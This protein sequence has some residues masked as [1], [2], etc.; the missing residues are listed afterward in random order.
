MFNILFITSNYIED[1][2]L[3]KA[4]KELEEMYLNEFQFYFYKSEEIDNSYQEFEKK[5]I[6]PNIIF[7]LL[8]GELEKFKKYSILK[9]KYAK[10]IPIFLNTTSSNDIMEINKMRLIKI[11]DFYNMTKYVLNG[12]IE[13][14]KNLILYVASKFG[15]KKYTY[16]ESKTIKTEGI[17]Y[18][19]RIVENEDEFL[20]S[21][22]NKKVIV[23]LFHSKDW[24]NKRKKVVDKFLEEIENNGMLGIG[25]F[26]NL[27]SKDLNG[28]KGIDWIIENYLKHN[29]KIIPKVI[30]NL[31]SYSLTVFSKHNK[32]EDRK[33]IFEDLN[34]PIIQAMSTYQERKEWESSIR[35]LDSESLAINVYYPEFDGQIITVT[36]CTYENIKDEIGERKIFIPIE[37]RVT[38]IVKIAKGWLKLSEKRNEEKKIAIIFHNMPPRNDMIGRAFGLDS[39]KSVYNMVELFKKNGIK[40]NYNFKNS[41]EIINKIIKGVSNDHKWL[42]AQK[43]LERS[44]DKINKKKYEIWFSE[45][46]LKV[47]SEMEK[48]WGKAPG[49]FMNYNE[50]FPI[51]GIIN[52]N[53]FIGLQPPR[54]IE[55]KADEIYHSTKFVIPHQY[56]AFYHWIKDIFK[57]DVIY[58]MGTHGTLEWLPGKEVGLSESCYPD[59]NIDDIPHLYPYSVNISGEGLQAKRRSNAVLISHMIP[60]LT[61]AGGYDEIEEIEELIKQYYH[62]K[63]INDK[64]I[65][66]IE[67]EII[68]LYFKYNYINDLKINFEEIERDF[69]VFLNKFHLYIDEIKSSVIKDGLHILGEIPDEK[70]LVGLIYNI[71][72]IK[73]NEMLAIDELVGKAIG[74]NIVE[75]KD[76]I[77]LSKI[78]ELSHKVIK[79]ILENKKIDKIE[80]YEIEDRKLIDM[81]KNYVLEIILPK[82]YGIK[83]E[84]ESIINGLNGKFVKPGES[85][86]IT[87]GNLNILPTGT[88]F[89]AIDPYK[90]PTKLS[91]K[92]GVNLAELLIERYRRDEGEL[93]KSIAMVLYSGDTIKTNGDDI[94]EILYLMGIKPIWEKNSEKVIGLEV[95]PLEEL[96]RPR[97]DV[98]L[99]ISGLFR[100]TFPVLIKMIDDAVNLVA[101]L[102]E[103]IEDNYI[104]KNIEEDIKKLIEMG[105]DQLEA[106]RKSKVR[107]F[108]CPPGTYGTGIRTLI[109]NKNWKDRKD[110][111]E[112]YINWSSYG[113][114]N[115]YHGEK[116]VTIFKEKLKRVSLTIK[117]EAS[118]E[119]DMLESDDY[120][121]YHGGLKVAVT[122]L[123]EEEVRSYSG[124]TSDID[125]IKIKSLNEESSRIM[126]ARILN[127]KWIEGLKKHD[128]KGAV[129]MSSML[130]TVFGWDATAQI[131]E[132]WMYDKILEKYLIDENTRKWL[133]KNNIHALLNMSERLLEAERRGMWKT[134][135][136]NIEVLTRIYLD[137][138][139]KV[140]EYE[141]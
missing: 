20:K 50:N 117:N 127:P 102:D 94:A 39:V 134:R 41:N 64:K 95:I 90:I 35:G 19:G 92:V 17:Y 108:G 89:Y 140:E 103:N 76:L 116:M 122:S 23:V 96:G 130:D 4:C 100:D 75:N 79:D 77:I 57:A 10:K 52:G 2:L 25:I 129:E 81:L 123:K 135:K 36:S 128:Y 1:Y 112:V 115:D 59:F 66:K 6:N 47:Q 12:G 85:G 34:I 37:N 49:T 14:Y 18:N 62:A 63:N 87:R 61:L 21:I 30:I 80:N 53:I 104:K 3:K 43:I 40:T 65:K 132:D 31:L 118:N 98:T 54:G 78:R 99:R 33:S 27:S 97:I 83:N 58:H 7:I 67:K 121:A 9:E 68:E 106:E 45:L 86:Y 51:P 46:N 126:R 125:N 26:T 69:S 107:V 114:T 38:K 13:N 109:E 133:E 138:E 55:E 56:Y 8:H 137:V 11:E 82:I 120:Y 24:W 93:P 131:I 32:I 72:K 105:Y 110:L 73:T 113:Y 70:K 28:A 15:Y 48:Q 74:V 101:N 111:G 88:N 136:E 42:D 16:L 139:G 71:L 5:Q 84:T 22:Y 119:I 124:N 141:D 91:W 29:G 60:A 44:V